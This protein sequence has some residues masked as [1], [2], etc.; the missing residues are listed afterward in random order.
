M[1]FKSGRQN[2]PEALRLAG[3]EMF[4]SAGGGRS[5]SSKYFVFGAGSESNTEKALKKAAKQLR[6]QGVSIMPVP[7]NVADSDK[8]PLKAIASAPSNNFYKPVADTSTLETTHHS[9]V[10][11]SIIPGRN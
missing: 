10:T 1:K 5:G 2:V 7:I 8:S 11:S 3:S 9:Q 6:Y 4:T